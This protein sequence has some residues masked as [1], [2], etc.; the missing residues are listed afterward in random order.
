MSSKQDFT[1]RKRIKSF[2]FAW[3]GIKLVWLQEYNFRIHLFITLAV[4]VLGFALNIL[5]VEWMMIIFAISIVLICEVINSALERICD[6]INPNIHP[7]IKIIKDI[8]AGSVLLASVGA[9]IIGLLVFLPYA[10]KIL[11][12]L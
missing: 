8:S 3:N 10:F 4:I 2:A 5:F 11:G 9:A 1:L 12:N 6:F 7:K